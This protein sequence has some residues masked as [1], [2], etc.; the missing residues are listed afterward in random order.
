[1]F[2]ERAQSTAL[3]THWVVADHGSYI[4]TGYIMI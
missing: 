2:M 3:R 1:M 4:I